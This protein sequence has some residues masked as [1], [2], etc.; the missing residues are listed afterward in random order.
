VALAN[1]EVRFPFIQQLGLVGPV[2]LGIFNLRGAA[3][4][5][6][7]AVWNQGDKLRLSVISEDRKD[8]VIAGGTREPFNGLGFGFGGGIRTALYFFIVKMDAAWNTDFKRTSR[9]RWHF[10]IGPEF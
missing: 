3:F 8:G 6:V 5:D 4:A 10:S 9:P 2:P 7:G 1:I